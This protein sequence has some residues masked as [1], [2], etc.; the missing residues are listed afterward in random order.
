MKLWKFARNFVFGP[1]WAKFV[2]NQTTD[3]Q[4]HNKNLSTMICE[5]FVGRLQQCFLKVLVRPSFVANKAICNLANHRKLQCNIIFYQISFHNP[6]VGLGGICNVFQNE[7]GKQGFPLSLPH[8]FV[9]AN[10]ILAV[11]IFVAAHCR[12]KFVHKIWPKFFTENVLASLAK[13]FCRECFD[14]F[15]QNFLRNV[16]ANMAKMFC[17]MILQR[18]RLLEA[19]KIMKL[20]WRSFWENWFCFWNRVA[21]VGWLSAS[22]K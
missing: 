16:L 3:C 9:L 1:V 20:R 11:E 7:F 17:N 5:P 14:K 12:P 13:M 21:E 10:L 6:N 2:N 8:G 19:F 18:N 15:C 22:A 4:Q